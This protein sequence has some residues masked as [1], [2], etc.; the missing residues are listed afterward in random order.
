MKVLLIEDEPGALR[1]L[2]KL[3]KSLRKHWEIVSSLDS[4]EAAYDF[5]LSHK[6]DLVVTDIHLADGLCFEIFRKLNYKGAVIFATAYDE[7]AIKAFKLNSVD[8]L[9][10]PINANDLEFAFN[11][12]EEGENQQKLDNLLP[13]FDNEKG[14]YKKRI[15]SKIGQ[16]I[17]MVEYEDIAYIFTVNGMAYVVDFNN[18]KVPVDESLDQLMAELPG[19]LFFRINRQAIVNVKAVNNMMVVSSSR[20]KLSLSLPTQLEMIV[21]KEKSPVFRTWIGGGT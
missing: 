19:D 9:L 13:L 7:Y 11:K 3:T 12:F 16:Q 18:N 5:L 14:N 1:R 15:I 6:V 20:L 8:Y 17:K 10:K 4:V 2:V 21:S